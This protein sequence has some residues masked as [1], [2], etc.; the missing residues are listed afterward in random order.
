MDPIS[1]DVGDLNEYQVSIS[2]GSDPDNSA[3]IAFSQH[4]TSHVGAAIIYQKQEDTSFNGTGDLTFWAQSS[5]TPGDPPSEVFRIT[6]DG[7]LGI[8]SG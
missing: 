8:R 1:N 3:G 7:N 5:N 6:D 2:G 4:G